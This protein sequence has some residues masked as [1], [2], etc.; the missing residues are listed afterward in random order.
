[1]ILAGFVMLVMIFVMIFAVFVLLV[2]LLVTLFVTSWFRFKFSF[3]GLFFFFAEDEVTLELLEV[4][5]K[6]RLFFEGFY[7][8]KC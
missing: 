4:E 6:L 1:M 5:V 2:T 3:F 7:K 8:D